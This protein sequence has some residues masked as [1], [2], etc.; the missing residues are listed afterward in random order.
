M[1]HITFLALAYL[2]LFTNSS[3]QAQEDKYKA[4]Q[5][6][7]YLHT[8]VAMLIS[9]WEK[10]PLNHKAADEHE[11][12]LKEHIIVELEHDEEWVE[13]MMVEGS[14]SH[15]EDLLDDESKKVISTNLKF[16]HKVLTHL[17]NP[18]EIDS[19]IKDWRIY[20]KKFSLSSVNKIIFFI[21]LNKLG[22]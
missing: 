2:F 4:I 19:K 18:E 11:K 17:R 22:M 10:H 13:Y 5:G 8:E 12:M 16:Y 3:M 6:F 7:G 20:T 15:F 9:H 1:K 21:L 14:L